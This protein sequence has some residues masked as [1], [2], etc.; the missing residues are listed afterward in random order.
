V[1]ACVTFFSRFECARC[2][3]PRNHGLLREFV[4]NSKDQRQMLWQP[5]KRLKHSI[6]LKEWQFSFLF[7]WKILYNYL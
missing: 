2:Q 4:A 1:F 7:G 3:V 5:P 6:R